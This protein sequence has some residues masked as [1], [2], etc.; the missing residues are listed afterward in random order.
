MNLGLQVG[1]RYGFWKLNLCLLKE[2][3]KKPCFVSHHAQRN[4]EDHK[5]QL[6][7][8]GA[9]GR[10][11]PAHGL[12]HTS[13]H[14]QHGGRAGPVMR[15]SA[16]QELSSAPIMAASQPAAAA[17]SGLVETCGLEPILEALKLLLSPGG[18]RT[19]LG[20]RLALRLAGLRVS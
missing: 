4:K 16:S 14:T 6:Q 10:A 7:G 15:Q 17:P 11:G 8:R 1:G 9:P 12:G 5:K 20:T 18:E 19:N 2:Q 13:R 3:H